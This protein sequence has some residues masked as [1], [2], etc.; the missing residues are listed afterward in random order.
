M[1]ASTHHDGDTN[2]KFPSPPGERAGVWGRV[3]ERRFIPTSPSHHCAMGLS[4]SPLKG[5]DG[6]IAHRRDVAR[7]DGRGY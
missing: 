2:S 1:A 4:L 6:L 5:G 3:P 7:R